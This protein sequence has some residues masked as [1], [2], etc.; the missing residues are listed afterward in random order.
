MHSKPRH[1]KHNHEKPRQ[2][3]RRH[4][5]AVRGQVSGSVLTERG[6]VT[7][8]LKEDVQG[9]QQLNAHVAAG[10]LP[11]DVQEENKH[12]LLQ[13]EAGERTRKHQ[14]SASTRGT[15]S[16]SP[17]TCTGPGPQRCPGS[18]HT[19][20]PAGS[21]LLAA[22]LPRCHLPHHKMQPLMLSPQNRSTGLILGS[23]DPDSYRRGK[24]FTDQVIAQ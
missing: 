20:R 16:P 6:L 12:V 10:F 11:Q 23:H 17:D 19:T 18:S 5:S 15:P 22:P 4:S 1:S 14:R 2:T 3:P 8:I 7:D 21:R 9:L 13:E 24:V